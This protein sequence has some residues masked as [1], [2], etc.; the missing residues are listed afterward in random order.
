MQGSINDMFACLRLQLLALER[1]VQFFLQALAGGCQLAGLL[2]GAHGIVRGLRAIAA[3]QQ[4]F[5]RRIAFVTADDRGDFGIEPVGR[6]A[7]TA[8]EREDHAT[9]Q[10]TEHSVGKVPQDLIE[11]VFGLAQVFFHGPLQQ[12]AHMFGRVEVVITLERG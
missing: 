8:T 9:Q 2:Q 10:A 11:G 5:E 3:L 4:L 7:V 12:G 1:R 6:P